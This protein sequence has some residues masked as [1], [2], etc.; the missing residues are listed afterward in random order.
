MYTV[1][2]CNEWRHNWKRKGWLNGRHS[3]LANVELWLELD[4]A[5]KAFPIRLEWVKG[6]AGIKATSGLTNCLGLDIELERLREAGL[7]ISNDGP[8]EPSLPSGLSLCLM[9]YD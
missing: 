9:P 8:L 5:L 3:K 2:G 4:A 7:S 6:H 1:K